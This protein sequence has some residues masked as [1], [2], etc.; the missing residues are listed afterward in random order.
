M[1]SK[2]FL[3]F[4]HAFLVLSF[5]FSFPHFVFFP[6][7]LTSFPFSF[8]SRRF[9]SLSSRRFLFLFPLVV[10]FPFPHF[11]SLCFPISRIISCPFSSLVV[12]VIATVCVIVVFVYLF[13]II[14]LCLGY[15]PIHAFLLC[16]IKM[17]RW[18]GDEVTRW[19]GDKATR[20]QGDKVTRWRSDKWKINSVYNYR[21]IH[22]H[23]LFDNFCK[24]KNVHVDKDRDICSHSTWA[25]FQHI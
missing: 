18:Q 24:D 15:H 1:L 11:V 16:C 12:D 20:R 2:Y 13:D 21:R 19:R 22:I 14:Y 10:F 4:R 23:T 3:F 25:P 5:P 6:F 8:S 7:F 9:L 17:T